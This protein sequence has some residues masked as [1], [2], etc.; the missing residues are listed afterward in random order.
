[1][2]YAIVTGPTRYIFEQMVQTTGTLIVQV[3]PRNFQMF[4][5]GKDPSYTL[6]WDVANNM[7][8]ISWT[9]FMAVFIASI[10]RGRTIRQFAFATM[11]I[12]VAFMLM[13][14]CTFGA[15]ALLNLILGDG[16]VAAHAKTSADMTFFALLKTLPLTPLISA[17]SVV[18]LLFFLATTVTSAALALGR[19]TNRDGQTPAPLRCAVWC[20]MMA[21]IALTGIFATTLGGND[22]LNA[23]RSLATTLSYPYMFVFILLATAFLRQ[24]KLDERRKPTPNPKMATGEELVRLRARVEAL[25]GEKI[26]AASG[27][28]SAG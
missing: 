13:W 24:I 23:I 6:T 27:Q 10:S 14:H 20:F 4:I 8:W 25:E 26:K 22:A 15:T 21:A 2:V 9:P 19:M 17:A 16:S 12:P 7:W 5:F 28:E 3:I 11:T 18:L 1:M